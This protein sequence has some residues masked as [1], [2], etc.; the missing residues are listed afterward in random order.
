MPVNVTR[1]AFKC[2]IFSLCFYHEIT[3]FCHLKLGRI[4]AAAVSS[5]EIRSL[6]KLL[7]TN[8][9]YNGKTAPGLSDSGTIPRLVKQ[10]IIH[11]SERLQAL[12]F[13][14]CLL[15]VQPVEF[16]GRCCDD[17]LRTSCWWQTAACMR[18]HTECRSLLIESYYLHGDVRLFSLTMTDEA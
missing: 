15:L 13:G 9:L 2:N 1:W 4:P 5:I 8:N 6:Q 11:V 10:E 12:R 7:T 17:R 18:R 3:F 16:N 14:K